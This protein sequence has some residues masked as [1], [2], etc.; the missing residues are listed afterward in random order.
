MASQHTKRHGRVLLFY[1]RGVIDAFYGRHIEDR[2][3]AG[4]NEVDL[5]LA[6]TQMKAAGF[7]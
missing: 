3:Q 6:F 4:A 1:C 5:E 7:I 2:K